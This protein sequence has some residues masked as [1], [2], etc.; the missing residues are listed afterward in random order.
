MPRSRLPAVPRQSR[1]TPRELP[2]GLPP[3][4][5]VP[6]ARQLLFHSWAGRLFLAAAGVKLVVGLLRAVATVPAPI[7]IISST[8]TLALVLSVVYFMWRLFVLMKRRLLWRVRRKLILSYIFIGVVP[9][10]LIISFFT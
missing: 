8:A 9:A 5:P 4:D 7:E 3:A 1:R 10:L 6:S 2:P